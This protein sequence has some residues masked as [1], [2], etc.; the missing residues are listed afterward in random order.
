MICAREFLR[1]LVRGDYLRDVLKLNER[2]FRFRRHEDSARLVL[3]RHGVDVF[4][5]VLDDPALP[6]AFH[7]VRLPQMR[8]DL[9]LVGQNIPAG[10]R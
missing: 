2:I 1:E 9:G 4:D 7:A 8:G 10:R 5:A 6:E 3:E